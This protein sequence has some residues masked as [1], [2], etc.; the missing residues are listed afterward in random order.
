MF[1][2]LAKELPLANGGTSYLDHLATD[3]HES[4]ASSVCM[5]GTPKAKNP[6]Q[7]QQNIENMIETS[8]TNSIALG[9]SGG[10]TL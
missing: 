7:R 3:G 5:V 6:V 2:D 1:L 10:V 8:S 9:F 4:F